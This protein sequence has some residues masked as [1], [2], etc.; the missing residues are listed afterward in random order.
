LFSIFDVLG[1]V[2]TDTERGLVVLSIFSD[3]F[4][5]VVCRIALPYILPTEYICIN[6]NITETDLYVVKSKED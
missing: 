6:I 4:W 3:Q 5:L 2:L 1:V